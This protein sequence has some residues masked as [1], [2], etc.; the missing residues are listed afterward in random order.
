MINKKSQLFGTETKIDLNIFKEKKNIDIAQALHHHEY[1]IK[2]LN[3]TLE[4]C[5]DGHIKY[6]QDLKQI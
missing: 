2:K 4:I 5:L 3:K 6:I 1:I